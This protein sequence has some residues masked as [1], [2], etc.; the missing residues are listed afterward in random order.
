MPRQNLARGGARA[1]SQFL[2]Y[3]TKNG[4]ARF[5]GLKNVMLFALLVVF[6]SASCKR[7]GISAVPGGWPPSSSPSTSTVSSSLDVVKIH[8]ESVATSA[9]EDAVATV[10]LSVTTGFHINANPA[11]FPYLIATELEVGNG[12]GMVTAG[13]PF[14]PRAQT[15]QFKFAEEPLAVYEGAV[16]ITLPV[17]TTS[18]ATRGS[19]TL[20][21]SVRVQACDEEKCFPPG[22][23]NTMIPIEVR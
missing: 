19:I 1:A 11:T 15:R 2:G 10:V 12:Y 13:K 5:S 21:I 17:R 9:G 3:N 14:Y 16:R 23:L 20:P 6:F 4:Q 8:A 7:N 18:K 22:T